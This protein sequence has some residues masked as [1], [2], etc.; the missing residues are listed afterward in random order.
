[1]KAFSDD[2]IEIDKYF[3]NLWKGQ[4]IF[5]RRQNKR[6]IKL[7][8]DLERVENIVGR[9]EILVTS[10]FSFSLNVFKRLPLKGHLK[11]GLCY[12]EL[13]LYQTIQVFTTLGKKP[14]AKIAE[15]EENADNPYFFVFPDNAFYSFQVKFKFHN[16]NYFVICKCFLFGLV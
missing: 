16:L 2:K 5:C 6:F 4:K 3:K 14:F 1:M 7:K 8:F 10:T 13:T 9:G 15:Q 12:K 11:S